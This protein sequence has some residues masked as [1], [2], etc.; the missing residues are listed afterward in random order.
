MISNSNAY[1]LALDVT[2][3][4]REDGRPAPAIGLSRYGF[5]TRSCGSRHTW[6]TRQAK[7]PKVALAL[8]RGLHPKSVKQLAKGSVLLVADYASPICFIYFSRCIY[9]KAPKRI[10]EALQLLQKLYNTDILRLAIKRSIFL[11]SYF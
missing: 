11:A 3:V 2:A 9:R 7:P 4:S 8:R 1:D 6:R 5:S 10:I